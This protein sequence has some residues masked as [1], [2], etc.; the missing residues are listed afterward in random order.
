MSVRIG[1]ETRGTSADVRALQGCHTH[2]S[3]SCPKEFQ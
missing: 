3:V 1:A 2:L